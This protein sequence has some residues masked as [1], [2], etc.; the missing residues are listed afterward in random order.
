MSFIFIYTHLPLAAVMEQNM[1][2]LF[3]FKILSLFSKRVTEG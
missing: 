2:L 1:M 3:L